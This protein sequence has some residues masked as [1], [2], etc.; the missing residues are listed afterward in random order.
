M[1]VKK[2]N[3][4]QLLHSC[5]NKDEDKV[6]FNV[7]NTIHHE[8]TKAVVA[9]ILKQNKH[10]Y[11]TEAIFANKK[12]ADIFDIT[13]E[14]AIE[15]LNT[16]EEKDLIKKESYPVNIYSIKVTD[17]IKQKINELEELIKKKLWVM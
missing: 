17:E 9:F 15:I 5:Y 1:I 6:K 14:I 10:S 2:Q 3:I 7:N 4:K 11:F 8:I 12:R 16:E 13:E